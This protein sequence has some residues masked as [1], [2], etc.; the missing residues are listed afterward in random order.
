[1]THLG[2]TAAAVI[3]TLAALGA[4]PDGDA[5]SD[6]LAAIRSEV[7]K[8][9]DEAISRL[10]EWIALPS[11]AAENRNYPAGAQFMAKLASDAGFQHVSVIDTD[12][13]PGVFA[14]LDAGAA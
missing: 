10:R 12:G 6:D 9:H 4:V 14:T 7:A 1:M 5:A 13:L 11:I 2:K 3:A 8:R